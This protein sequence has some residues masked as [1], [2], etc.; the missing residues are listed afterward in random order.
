[1]SAVELISLGGFAFLLAWT[2]I[3]FF[4]L[5]RDF[6]PGVPLE[7]RDLTQLGVFASIPLGYGILHLLGKMPR[8]NLFSIPSMGAELVFS[9]LLPIMAF[10]M[11]RGMPMPLGAVATAN[12]LAGMASAAL[13]LSWLD[14]LSRLRTSSFGRFTSL[15]F[16]L[17]VLLF[18]F[19]VFMPSDVQPV[20]GIVYVLLTICLLAFATQNAEGNDAAAPLEAVAD[21]WR[22]TKEIEPS[23]FVFGIVF[24]LNFV[25]VF[26]YGQEA[27]LPAM[28]A[29][30]PGALLMAVLYSLKREIGITVVQRILLII[31]V[32]SCIAMP[33]VELP[34]QIACA[35]LVAAAWA[36]FRS[37]HYALV[38]QKCVVNHTSPLFRQAPS[39]LIIAPGGFALGWAIAAAITAVS[40]AHSDPFTT[41]RLVMALVLVITVMAFYPQGRHHLADGTAQEDR[42]V[43]ENPVAVQMNESELLERRCAAIAKLYQLSPRESDILIYLARGRNAAW[44]QEELVISPHTVKSHIY[45]IYRKLDIHSQQKLMS[46]VEEYP[47]EGGADGALHS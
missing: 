37:V 38:V 24:G 8:F 27:L 39:R 43:P 19:A 46:F 47:V 35:S 5:F 28:L 30:A 34:W 16:V 44:I 33:F 7:V 21:P 4:W 13:L 45:N 41:V 32:L 3:G 20:F 18:L 26:N 2:F 29:M 9:L 17:A 25:F 22:F 31:T 15:A 36:A 23:F 10:S 42:A 1:M 12:V 14:V 11:Y 40:G 6:P